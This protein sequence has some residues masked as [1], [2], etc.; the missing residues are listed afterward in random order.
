MPWDSLICRRILDEK[1]GNHQICQCPLCQEARKNES[2]GLGIGKEDFSVFNG[3]LI[4]DLKE[5]KG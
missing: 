1:R 4:E 2:E 3:L 5:E